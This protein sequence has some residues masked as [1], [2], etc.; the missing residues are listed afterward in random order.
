[1]LTDKRY[2]DVDVRSMLLEL[3]MPRYLV[4]MAIPMVW[5]LVGTTDPDNAAVIEIIKSIQKRL[6][7]LG[8]K[9]VLVSGVMDHQTGAALARV[10]GPGWQQKSWIQLVGD[11][12]HATPGAQ[13]HDPSTGLGSYF[14]YEGPA[15]GPLPGYKVGLP[16]G[17][18]G[19]LGATAT[20]NG[21]ELSYGPGQKN[22]NVMVPADAETKAVFRS[23]Q[24]NL[25]RNL[26]PLQKQV[27]EDG[28]IGPETKGGVSALI[29]N[30]RLQEHTVAIPLIAATTASMAWR[31][32]SLSRY[33]KKEAD[34]RGISPGANRPGSSAPRDTLTVP[35]SQAQ[36]SA[37]GV[38]GTAKGLAPY[39]L[40]AGG[41]AAAAVYYKRKGK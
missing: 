15:P 16:P 24:R 32:A 2:P 28:V 5:F 25:N 10:S 13:Y 29:S 6:R 36:A 31:A 35:L 22:P 30:K 11:V 34:L 21:V 19:A 38:A 26:A 1:M 4:T 18:L 17:P 8:Y 20:D 27:A 39:L 23:V 33:L 9:N 14:E 40:L 12:L 3:G 37:K 7:R 41:V